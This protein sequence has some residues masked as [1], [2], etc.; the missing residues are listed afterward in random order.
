MFN[1]R[2]EQAPNQTIIEQPTNEESK[3]GARVPVILECGKR[4]D[5]EATERE[6]LLDSVRCCDCGFPRLPR[7]SKVTDARNV[8][9]MKSHPILIN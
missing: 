3:G 5:T 7:K 2:W 8:F 1:F 6:E 9:Y 4:N